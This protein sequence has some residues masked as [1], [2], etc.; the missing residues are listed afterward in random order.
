M[1]DARG[2]SENFKVVIGKNPKVY[3]A[4]Y[5]LGKAYENMSS[6]DLAEEAF[7]K[8]AYL[9]NNITDFKTVR[10]NYFPLPTKAKFELARI[11][12]NTRRYDKAEKILTDIIQRNHTIG[13]VYRLL[14]MFTVKGRFILEQEIHYSGQ[15]SS[16]SF[17]FCRYLADKL[18]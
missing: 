3:L 12:L 14:E 10:V 15:G 13:P 7:N 2:A 6:G 9:N 17:S 1:G 8:I 11:Y 4:W 18:H 5:Y 16:G